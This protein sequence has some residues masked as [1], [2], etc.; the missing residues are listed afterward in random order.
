M[1]TRCPDCRRTVPAD[2]AV[3]PEPTCRRSL[4]P[5]KFTVYNASTGQVVVTNL[6]EQ[7]AENVA[8]ALRVY[9]QVNVSVAAPTDNKGDNVHTSRVRLDEI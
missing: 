4:T 2:A 7:Q 1:N 6:S 5:D 3:C 8:G 9:G